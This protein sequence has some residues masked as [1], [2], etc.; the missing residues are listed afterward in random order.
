M[1]P[2]ETAASSSTRLQREN[3]NDENGYTLLIE[4]LKT[5]KGRYMDVLTL[6]TDSQ[7]QSKISVRV[8]G[9]ILEPE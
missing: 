4:N 2:Q 6:T 5:D 9:N 1:W 8:Y 3:A 7:I